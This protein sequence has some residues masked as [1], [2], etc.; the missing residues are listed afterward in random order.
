[1]EETSI[2]TLMNASEYGD[3]NGIAAEI[4]SSLLGRF[5]RSKFVLPSLDKLDF[6][7]LLIVHERLFPVNSVLA[8]CRVI[9]IWN[10][11]LESARRKLQVETS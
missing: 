3:W 5:R 8:S 4:S 11:L 2:E 9:S 7:T 10:I 6:R 1:M